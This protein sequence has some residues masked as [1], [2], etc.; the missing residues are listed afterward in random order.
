M[1]RVSRDGYS[2]DLDMCFFVAR[3]MAAA[4]PYEVLDS[5][6]DDAITE[7]AL[8]GNINPSTLLSPVW[9]PAICLHSLRGLSHVRQKHV[10]A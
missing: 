5:T 3:S 7:V 6:L 4:Y 9:T 2:E 1:F 10:M 8:F